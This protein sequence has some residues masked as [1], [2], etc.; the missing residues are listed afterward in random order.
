VSGETG[1]ISG[2][3][4]LSRIPQDK[5]I[6]GAEMRARAVRLGIPRCLNLEVCPKKRRVS[7]KRGGRYD[8]V[9]ES[10]F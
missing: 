2:G 9:A 7:Y 6:N 5:L 3:G 10:L 4:K 1:E 8:Q